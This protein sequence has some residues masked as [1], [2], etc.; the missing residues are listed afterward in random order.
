MFP[1]T[2]IKKY[3]SVTDVLF[4]IAGAFIYAVSVNSFIYPAGISAG[5]ITGIATAL[6]YLS[7]VPA[8]ITV[9]ILNVPLLILAFKNF[10]GGFIFKTAVSVFTVSLFLEIL[11]F[12]PRV[13]DDILLSAVFGGVLMGFGLSLFLIRG[14]TTGGVDIIAKKVNTAKPHI[15]VGRVI[16]CFDVAVISFNAL[17]YGNITSA[18]YSFLAMYLS[19]RT[20][21]AVIYGWDKSKSVFIVSE[22]SE[23]IRHEIIN[24]LNR[25][26]TEIK[27]VG[28]YTGKEKN[29]LFCVIRISETAAIKK[30]IRENDEFAFV[31]FVNADETVG[32]GFRMI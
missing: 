22:K 27:S 29:M 4:F 23:K 25:G 6:R 32:N 1:L 14:A 19:S 2:K 15:S 16:L 10:G 26:V 5:G 9:L 18:L 11:S 20:V 30:I 21:D 17:V 13:T 24:T 7:G 31:I 8:G 28:G 3:I 12:L